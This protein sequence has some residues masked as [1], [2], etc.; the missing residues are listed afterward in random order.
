[1]AVVVIVVV[2]MLTVK[3]MVRLVNMMTLITRK[4]RTLAIM[5]H[6]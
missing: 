1:M 5:I 3:I 6:M 2:V 4:R